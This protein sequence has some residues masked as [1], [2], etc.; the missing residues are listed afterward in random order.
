MSGY[1]L[2]LIIVIATLF[3]ELLDNSTSRIIRA[4]WGRD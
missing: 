2:I 3:V 4:M 1:A